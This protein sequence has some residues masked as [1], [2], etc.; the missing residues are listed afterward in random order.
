MPLRAAHR[1]GESIY[2]ISRHSRVRRAKPRYWLQDYQ[3]RE[4]PNLPTRVTV[5]HEAS[6]AM[7]WQNRVVP[8]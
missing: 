8:R 4:P 2:P 7:R 6:A 3:P 5:I 1:T